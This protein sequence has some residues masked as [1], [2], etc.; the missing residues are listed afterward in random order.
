MVIFNG[1]AFFQGLL[2]ALFFGV[3]YFILYL[4]NIDDSIWEI[5]NARPMAVIFQ[6]HLC[7]WICMLTATFGVN[8]RLFFIPTWILFTAL[9]IIL[10]LSPEAHWSR[11]IFMMVSFAIPLAFFRLKRS[12]MKTAWSEAHE[13]LT[14]LK[15]GTDTS[16]IEYWKLVQASAIVPQYTFFTVHFYW[17]AMYYGIYNGNDWLNHYKE[18]LPIIGNRY[19][20]FNQKQQRKYVELQ[21]A[22]TIALDW[23][24]YSHPMHALSTLH[25][26]I[27]GMIKMAEKMP[28]PEIT[29]IT[30]PSTAKQNLTSE[31]EVRANFDRL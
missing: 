18:L 20:G 21:Q 13:A 25:Y 31:K 24:Q 5:G 30:G 15:S 16:Q 8:G 1:A 3:I 6:A 9:C 4:F 29:P 12:F 17:K 7:A 28:Q 11:Y 22:V 19:V 10:C 23:K 27:E 14:L 2:L 26:S